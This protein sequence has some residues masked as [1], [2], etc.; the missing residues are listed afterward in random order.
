VDNV[1][2]ESE[3]SAAVPPNPP[4]AAPMEFAPVAIEVLPLAPTP[5]QLIL[6]LAERW[7]LANLAPFL[8]I[9]GA[10]SAS[11]VCEVLVPNGKPEK[12]TAPV[13]PD[14]IKPD[15][16]E[17]NDR[18]QSLRKAR[19]EAIK[20]LPFS[21]PPGLWIAI[22]VAA[23]LAYVAI[24]Y[25]ELRALLG[26]V[27]M[28][29]PVRPLPALRAM[30]LI[31]VIFVYVLSTRNLVLLVLGRHAGG[32]SSD[33]AE[34]MLLHAGGLALGIVTGILLARFRARHPRGSNGFWPF[35]T[36]PAG[37]TRSVWWD[38]LIGVAAYP[39]WMLMLSLSA[40]ANQ[41]IV[42][43]LGHRPDEHPVIQELSTPQSAS[44]LAI[45]FLMVTAGAAFFEEILFRGILYNVARR[46]SGPVMGAIIAGLIFAILHQIESQVLAL[47]VLA[48]ILTWLYDRTGR[49]IA[50][51][52]LH[53]LNNL[54]VLI[55]T[56]LT[57][58][59]G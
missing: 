1:P 3:P 47:F 36:L 15:K 27:F 13:L 21:R 26:I 54:V 5:F 51:M 34:A 49:L 46:Y 23:M 8:V 42:Y 40:Y 12:I 11:I 9:A 25:P 56:L 59:Y 38:V 53:A 57:S 39:P 6:R 43:L 10:L 7:L 41:A 4:D 37:Q 20:Q 31:A 28:K 24:T 50:G 33:R 52:T 30:D 19:E 22:W 44:V 16:S 18:S 29:N 45:Y 14:T 2:H 35:W 58:H 48:L 17:K 32:E 55:Y